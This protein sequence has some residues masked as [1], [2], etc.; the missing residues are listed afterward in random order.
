M[1]KRQSFETKLIHAGEPEKKYGDAVS[2]PIFQSS[3]FEMIRSTDYHDIKYIR[4]N[5]TPNHLAVHQKLAAIENGEDALVTSSGMAAISTTLLSLLKSGDHFLAHDSLYGGTHDLINKDF[6]DLGIECNYFDGMDSSCWQ[7][8]LQPQTK[9]IYVETVTNP[10]MSV[11]DLDAIIKFAKE[12]NLYSLID[13]TFASPVNYRPLEHG[14]D[15]SIHSATKYLNGHTDIVAGVVV[16]EKKIIESIRHKLNHLGGT[17][18]PH[19]CFLL[20]R[21]LKTLSL[22]VKRQNSN[23]LVI[24]QYLENHSKVRKVNYPGLKSSPSYSRAKKFFDGFGGMISFELDGGLGEAEYFISRLSLFINAPSLGGV[25]SLVTRPAISSHSG[26]SQNERKNAGI[27]DE[28]I[29]MSVGIESVEDLIED[30]NQAL[31]DV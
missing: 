30:L 17:L 15:L 29:R 4:L 2:L 9:L 20:Y 13:N 7:E 16:G 10:L 11:L 6:P 23:S 3:T 1:N 8:K 22:R 12:N 14:F 27:K 25:E 28:L 18:D 24:A 31:H 21:G 19:A 26:M 5:N